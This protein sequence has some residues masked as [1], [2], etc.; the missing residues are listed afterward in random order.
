MKTLY[1]IEQAIRVCRANAFIGTDAEQ[2]ANHAELLRLKAL[3]A[4]LW[5]KERNSRPD[6]SAMFATYGY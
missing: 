2:A 1:Q 4:P 3:A 5:A 6:N